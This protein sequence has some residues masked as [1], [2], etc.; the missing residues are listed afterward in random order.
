M[1]QK[2]ETRHESKLMNP[3]NL[4]NNDRNAAEHPDDQID[5]L[6]RAYKRFGF[7]GAVVVGTGNKILAG[8]GRVQAAIKAG[9]KQIPVIDVSMLS[10]DEQD[11]FVISENKISELKTWNEDLLDAELDRLTQLDFSLE[12]LGISDDDEDIDDLM[13]EASGWPREHEE[14]KGDFPSPD[15]D[16]DHDGNREEE[17][18]DDDDLK[19]KLS[20]PKAKAPSVCPNC[21]HEYIAVKRDCAA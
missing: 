19:P 14:R 16:F 12:E 11:A 17:L 21:G 3:K 4:V 1:S 15:D 8:H 18:E 10:A 2:I 20:A 7:I 6:V 5:S 9:M 13:E